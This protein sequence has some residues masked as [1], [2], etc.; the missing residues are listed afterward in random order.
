MS[1]GILA[2]CRFYYDFFNA[3]RQMTDAD[4]KLI[5]KEMDKIVKQKL[6]LVREEVT[7]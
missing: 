2:G 3:E 7:R 6:P 4:L 1:N 5:K